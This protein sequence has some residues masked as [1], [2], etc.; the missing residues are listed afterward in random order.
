MMAMASIRA[1]PT[2]K[3]G[4]DFENSRL[5]NMGTVA[6]AHPRSHGIQKWILPGGRGCQFSRLMRNWKR[7]DIVEKR[8]LLS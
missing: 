3:T 1:V 6:G 2:K 5:L 4:I 7:G 8:N